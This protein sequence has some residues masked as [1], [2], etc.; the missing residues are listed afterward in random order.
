MSWR[1]A[2]SKPGKTSEE[3]ILM[4]QN[5]KQETNSNEQHI[6]NEHSVLYFK[7]MKVKNTIIKLISKPRISAQTLE[8]EFIDLKNPYILYTYTF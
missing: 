6:L 4:L 3:K 2:L 1:L 5:N 8:F 7:S